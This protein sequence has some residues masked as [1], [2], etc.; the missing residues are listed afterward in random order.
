[1]ESGLPQTWSQHLK[2]SQEGQK[3]QLQITIGRLCTVPEEALE[4]GVKL[5]QKCITGW[6]TES[7][8]R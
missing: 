5:V 8:Q 1:M 7:V 4:Q 6:S 2:C 3:D